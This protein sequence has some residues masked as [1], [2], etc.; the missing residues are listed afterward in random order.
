MSTFIVCSLSERG[1]TKFIFTAHSRLSEACKSRVIGLNLGSGLGLAVALRGVR[2][3]SE[4]SVL[5]GLLSLAGPLTGDS[6]VD[7]CASTLVDRG[8]TTNASLVLHSRRRFLE[9]WIVSNPE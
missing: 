2:G 9:T 5:R 7:L 1:N 4:G 6:A 3:C 8:V